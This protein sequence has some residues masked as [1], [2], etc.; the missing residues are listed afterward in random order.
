[1]RVLAGI[2]WLI[3]IVL[4]VV[5]SALN[6]HAVHFNYY[7]GSFNIYL[8]LLLLIVLVLGALLGIVA[9]LPKLI[10]A[11]A[12]HRRLKQQARHSAQEVENLRSIP[13]KDSH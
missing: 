2:F 9:M 11:K 4:A 7:L 13:I 5:F 12:K 1:M 8:P 6:S 3:I 10:R